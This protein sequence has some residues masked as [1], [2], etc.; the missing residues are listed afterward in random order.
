VGGGWVKREAGAAGV[1]RM[2]E[3]V[4]AWDSAAGGKDASV[5]PVRGIVM[6]LAAAAAL[7]RGWEIHRGP[8]ALMAYGLGALA[9]GLGVWHLARK[10]PASRV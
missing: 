4:G 1:V 6:L 9:L 7:W 3:S 10:P 2:D 8:Y 5:S